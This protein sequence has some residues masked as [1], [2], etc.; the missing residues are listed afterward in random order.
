MALSN[1]SL[2]DAHDNQH[3]K[4]TKVGGQKTRSHS[5]KKSQKSVS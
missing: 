1:A 3:Q 2:E 4:E 5:N